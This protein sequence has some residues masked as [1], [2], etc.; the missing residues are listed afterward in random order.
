M[1]KYMK[2]SIGAILLL[3]FIALIWYHIP[4][5]TQKTVMACTADGETAEVTFDLSYERH[6][7]GE[8]RCKGNITVDGVIYEDMGGI[9]GF[10]K[11]GSTFDTMHDNWVVISSLDNRYR[12][13][14]LRV[15]I[16]DETK[17]YY[18]EAQNAEEAGKVINK[19]LGE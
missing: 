14:C 1:K 7:L 9:T 13:F 16:G 17:T 5:K 18:G 19:F 11:E 4:V 8:P 3:A 2:Y 12:V 15:I 10:T 6:I